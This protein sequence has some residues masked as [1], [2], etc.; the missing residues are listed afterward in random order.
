MHCV[1]ALPAVA[2]VV[3]YIQV[4]RD[5]LFRHLRFSAD[6]AHS[7]LHAVSWEHIRVGSCSTAVVGPAVIT[8]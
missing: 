8:T 1:H 3:M 6:R 2:R 4:Y 5:C 7:L